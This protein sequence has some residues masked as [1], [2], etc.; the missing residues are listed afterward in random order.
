MHLR[1]A[2]H[3]GVHGH[4]GS[5]RAFNAGNHLL[6]L[7]CARGVIDDHFGAIARQPVRDAR[8]DTLRCARDER[9]FPVQLAHIV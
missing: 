8:A 3:I 5:T 4:G 2:A 6:C 1:S 9:H 7:V